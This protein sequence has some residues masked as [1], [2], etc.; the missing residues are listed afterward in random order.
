MLKE[1]NIFLNIS[2]P[3]PIHTMRGYKYLNYEE[4]DFPIT[5]KNAKEIFSL[6]MFPTLSIERQDKV[7]KEI[8]SVLRIID[9]V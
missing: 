6:P 9:N 7:I 4:G 2:Y 3:H 8:K 5:E 1:R